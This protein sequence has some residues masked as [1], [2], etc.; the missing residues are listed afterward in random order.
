MSNPT[1]I[2][3]EIFSEAL[4]VLLYVSSFLN[5]KRKK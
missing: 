1:E 4:T 5:T 2:I 3:N